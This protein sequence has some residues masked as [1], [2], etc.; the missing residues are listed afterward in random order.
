MAGD[1]VLSTV[2]AVGT[3]GAIVPENPSPGKS[4]GT[5]LIAY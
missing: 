3:V 1:L 4:L 2:G 5:N